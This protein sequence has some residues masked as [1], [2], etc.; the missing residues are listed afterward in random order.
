[1]NATKPKPL[2]AER[3]V[4]AISIDE[5]S[6][7][8]GLPVAGILKLLRQTRVFGLRLGSVVYVS[9]AALPVFKEEVE[10]LEKSGALPRMKPPRK[11][12]VEN[13]EEEST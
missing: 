13:T 2:T 4:S 5:A 6:E 12:H 9:D 7:E 11:R 10:R 3:P 8:T 1:M